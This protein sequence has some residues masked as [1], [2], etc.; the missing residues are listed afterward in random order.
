MGKVEGVDMLF[1]GPNDLSCSL[2]KFAQYEDPEFVALIEKAENAIKET[3]KL[4][5]SIP[6][7]QFGWQAMFDRGFNLTTAG[8][9]VALLREAAVNI[10]KE[11]TAHNRS[12]EA[13]E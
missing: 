8:T 12:S 9:E 5:G 2:N 1:I 6:Y 3:G 11:H 10:M 13:A 7:G 4:L